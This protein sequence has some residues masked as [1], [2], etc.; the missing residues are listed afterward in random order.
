MR[1]LTQSN[2]NSEDSE[3]GRSYISP[4]FIQTGKGKFRV[5]PDMGAVVNPAESFCVIA[6][7][8]SFH[9]TM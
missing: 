2:Q 7:S 9:S 5:L 6:H 1:L 3:S 8:V 4:S